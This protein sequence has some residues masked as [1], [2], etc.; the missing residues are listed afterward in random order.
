M[1]EISLECL[2]LLM[3]TGKASLD[4]FLKFLIFILYFRAATAAAAAAAASGNSP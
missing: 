4:L 1:Q 3:Q 2:W